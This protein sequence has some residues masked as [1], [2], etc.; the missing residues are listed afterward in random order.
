[1]VEHWA[2]G[3]QPGVFYREGEECNVMG[4][5]QIA[6]GYWA[7]GGGGRKKGAERL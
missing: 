6:I 5:I 7:G 3:G 1:M 2:V 4:V